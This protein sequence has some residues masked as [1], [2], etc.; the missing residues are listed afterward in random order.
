M[1]YQKSKN[2]NDANGKSVSEGHD[3]ASNRQKMKLMP[4]KIKR[5]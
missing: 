2:E 4:T 1:L 3:A 5:D